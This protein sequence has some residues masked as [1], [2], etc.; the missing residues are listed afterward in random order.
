[1]HVFNTDVKPYLA[2][3]P[4]KCLQEAVREKKKIYPEVCLQQCHHFLPLVISDDGLLDVEAAAT[5]KMISSR[6][7]IKWH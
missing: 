1:M 4:K 7:A 6:L 2:N 3:T 5:Q